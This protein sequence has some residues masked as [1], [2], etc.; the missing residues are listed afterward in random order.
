MSFPGRGAGLSFPRPFLS[1]HQRDE[2]R[3]GP[4]ASRFRSCL[5]VSTVAQKSS[6]MCMAAAFVSLALCPEPNRKKLT[7]LFLF[8]TVACRTLLD[9]L[10]ER[11]RCAKAVALDRRASCSLDSFSEA[12]LLQMPLAHDTSRVGPSF[13]HP[14][15]TSDNTLRSYS[16]RCARNNREPHVESCR[17]RPNER[18]SCGSELA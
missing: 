16:E 2:P 9:G 6:A 11:G 15:I 17:R 18:S 14:T 3:R 7:F 8:R 10:Q 13:T 5:V 12:A 1:R 4:S